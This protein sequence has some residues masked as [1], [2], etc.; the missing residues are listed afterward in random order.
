MSRHSG[1]VMAVAM[2]VLAT[3]GEARA[4]T[5]RPA[6]LDLWAAGKTAFGVFVPDENPA[7]RGPNRGPA[8]YTASGGQALAANPLID[9]VFLNL[10]QRYDRTAVTAISDGLGK[11][12][13][14]GRKLMLVRIP[15][16]AEA[17][18]VETLVRIK[19]ILAMGADG[20][21]LPHIENLDQGRQAISLF[22]DARANVWSAANPTGTVVAMLMLED[23]GAVAQAKGIADIGGYSVLACGIGSLTGALTGDRAAAEKGN[24]EILVETKRVKLVNMLT[25]SAG[26]VAQRVKEGFLGLLVPN[27]EVIKA[28]RAA[29]D[30]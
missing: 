16:L 2:A 29:A 21:T 14:R 28:G 25:A 7:P 27:D 11:R 19:E 22:A 6:V 9:F 23:P 5:V 24:Q 17:G 3:T 10:E 18:P 15:A 1:V 30:R 13:T 8:V 26:D 20:V 12:G 4:Q